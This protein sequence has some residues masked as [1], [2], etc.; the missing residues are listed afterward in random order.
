MKKILKSVIYFFV[1]FIQVAF[2]I[3]MIILQKQTHKSAG[4]NHH[5]YYR[6]VQY[7]A[8]YFTEMNVMIITIILTLLVILLLYYLVKN[9]NKIKK[10]EKV[11]VVLLVFWLVLII[12]TFK[13]NYLNKLLVYPYL[14]LAEFIS[15]GL[16]FIIYFVYCYQAKRKGY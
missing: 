5:L 9:I 15:L 1:K 13:I 16:E 3:G 14:I 4:V 7:R 12:A 11:E 10:F 8:K 6:K 2:M